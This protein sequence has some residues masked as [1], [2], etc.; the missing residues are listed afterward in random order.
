MK[1]GSVVRGTYVLRRYGRATCYVLRGTLVRGT[2]AQAQDTTYNIHGTWYVAL[3][4]GTWCA[5]RPTCYC[6]RATWYRSYYRVTCYVAVTCYRATVLRATVLR[7]T[8]L[9]IHASVLI[10]TVLRVAC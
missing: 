1:L 6:Y 9:L 4:R 5:L 3:A 2:L 8:V 7:T 10:A